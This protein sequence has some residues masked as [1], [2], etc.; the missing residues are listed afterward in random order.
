MPSGTDPAFW[1]GSPDKAW[2][3]KTRV[4]RDQSCRN[5]TRLSPLYQTRSINPSLYLNTPPQKG[6]P[7]ASRAMLEGLSM[8]TRR[9]WSSWDRG[10]VKMS[11]TCNQ[12]G[13]CLALSFQAEQALSMKK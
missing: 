10:L 4:Q 1:R 5:T 12:S 2:G 8:E 7:P 6:R 13:I 9:M 3:F 11:A